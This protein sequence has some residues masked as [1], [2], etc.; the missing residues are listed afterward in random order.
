MR[1]DIRSTLQISDIPKGHICTISVIGTIGVAKGNTLACKYLPLM[2][3][4]SIPVSGNLLFQK[5][6]G[7]AGAMTHCYY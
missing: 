7:M 3:C 4:F 6:P 2:I 1:R 5:E